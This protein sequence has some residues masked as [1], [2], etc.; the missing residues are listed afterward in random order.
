M[1]LVGPA[2]VDGVM[3]TLNAYDNQLYAWGKGPSATTVS[4]PNL[5]VT[6]ATPITITGTVTDISAGTK[7]EAP[8]ANFPYGVPCVSEASQSQ[9]ME[10]VYMQQPMPTNT[11]GVQ[12]TISV[13]DSNGNTR[14]IGTTTT[15]SMGVYGFSW[16]PDIRGSYSLIVRFAGSESYFGSSA[17][18]YFYASEAPTPPP[19]TI[20][21]ASTVTMGDILPYLAASVIAIIVAIAIVGL[22]I[23]KKRP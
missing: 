21:Q 17:S 4:A 14:E 15:N 1:L 5:G 9:F 11:T 7:Q 8:A 12:V 19:T 13:A 2:I 18:T 16:T 10:A 3:T 22:I 20:T 6:T 23:L